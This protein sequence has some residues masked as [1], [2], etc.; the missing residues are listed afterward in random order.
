M[1]AFLGAGLLGSGFVRALRGRGE[2]VNVWNRTVAKASALEAHGAKA[3]ADP[4]LA[5]QGAA[6]VHL[7]LSDDVAVDDV[8]ER[9]RPSLAKNVVIVD[10]TTTSPTGTKARAERWASL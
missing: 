6:R 3:F 8:L 4:A 1:I 2:N 10:H 5:V 9:A 7:A